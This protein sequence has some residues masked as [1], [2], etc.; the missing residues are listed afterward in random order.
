M[1]FPAIHRYLSVSGA[2]R[3]SERWSIGV[4]ISGGVNPDPAAEQDLCDALTA[5]P[6]T[7]WWSVGNYASTATIDTV[8]LNMIGTDGKYVNDYT[9]ATYLEDALEGGGGVSPFPNQVALVI[10]LET[11]LQRGLAHRGRVF[12]PTPPGA[13]AAVEADGRISSTNAG[14]NAAAFGNFLTALNGFAGLGT[15]V[16]ASN[17]REGAQRPVTSVSCGRVLDT[18]RSRRTQLDEERV[19]SAVA[20]G[21]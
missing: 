5:G 13:V 4:R 10:T 12:I 1:A 20:G 15:V 18:M 9:I 8:K 21:S 11:G 2:L 7:S 6:V 14:S 19:S 3:G 16:V 17:T